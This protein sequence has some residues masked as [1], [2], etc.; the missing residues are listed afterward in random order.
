MIRRGVLL[1]IGLLAAGEARAQ[2]WPL[3]TGPSGDIINQTTADFDR[4]RRATPALPPDTSFLPGR[5][6]VS[7]PAWTPPP[8]PRQRPVRR[9]TAPRQE[10]AVAAAPAPAP[11]AEPAKR[12]PDFEAVERRL[13]ERERTLRDLQRDLVE[14]RKLV[15]EWR[16]G[17]RT[18][19]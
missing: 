15:D 6:A 10:P 8:M 16:G 18:A 7:A 19:R 1:A 11:T 13:A 4:L 3:Q 2:S 17:Q 9:T 14:E 12:Q 5:A